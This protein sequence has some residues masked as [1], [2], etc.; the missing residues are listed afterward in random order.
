[1]PRT[2]FGPR[3]ILLVPAVA[4]SLL[5]SGGSASAQESVAPERPISFG[6]G[7][8][9]AAA[10]GRSIGSV[11]LATLE[12]AT[13]WRNFGVRLDGAITKWPGKISGSRLT[14]LTANLVYSHR[15]G[16]F[17]PYLIGGIGGYAE[18]GTGASFG[19]NAGVGIKASLRRL[20]PFIELREHV[21]SAD[22]TR[23]ATPLTVGLMF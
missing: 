22:R 9:A 3:C 21:W 16:V 19:L 1:M 15:L 23:R 2:W 17:S 12:L 8:G 14:N 13:P 20:Q 18:Q 10:P 7:L 4:L 5:L 6:L 11:G